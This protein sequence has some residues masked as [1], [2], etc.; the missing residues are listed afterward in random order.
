MDRKRERERQEEDLL[1]EDLKKYLPDTL[2]E[3]KSED[4]MDRKSGLCTNNF[5]LPNTKE[6]LAATA[7]LL[8]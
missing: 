7:S 3:N 5:A 2:K 6:C 4:L 8:T 1:V